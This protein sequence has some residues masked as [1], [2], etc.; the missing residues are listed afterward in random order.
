MNEASSSRSGA[1]RHGTV[2]A[3]RGAVID[4]RFGEGELPAIEDALI[5]ETNGA[6][7]YAEVQAHLDRSSVRAIA[8]QS[9]VG[10]SRGRK[11]RTKGRPIEIPVGDATLGRLIDVTGAI[12]DNGPPLPA[13]APRR[14]IHRAAPALA[15]R[16]RGAEIFATGIKIIDLLTPIAQ[17]GKAAMFGGAGVGKTVLVME[18]IHAM[19][20]GYRGVSVF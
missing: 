1:A 20:S 13:D 6:E 17:G 18:L 14:P 2:V 4:V 7:I 9:T 12:G 11:V 8:L 5:V 19:V 15:A 10:L 16:P 3:V